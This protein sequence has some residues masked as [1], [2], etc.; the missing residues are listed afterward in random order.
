MQS[1]L[2]YLRDINDRIIRTHLIEAEFS[3]VCDISKDN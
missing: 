1:G 3:T 2:I